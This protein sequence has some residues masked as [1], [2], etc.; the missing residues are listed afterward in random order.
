MIATIPCDFQVLTLVFLS[1]IWKPDVIKGQCCFISASYHFDSH[2]DISLIK[3]FTVDN[4][5]HSSKLNTLRTI[6]LFGFLI[7]W[8]QSPLLFSFPYLLCCYFYFN[9]YCGGRGPMSDKYKCTASV[10][11][12]FPKPTSNFEKNEAK[13]ITVPIHHNKKKSLPYP[14]QYKKSK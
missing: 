11:P 1:R 2:H 4:Q 3:F 10:F 6:F 5:T 7:L 9:Y 14:P 8:P 13:K 12:F